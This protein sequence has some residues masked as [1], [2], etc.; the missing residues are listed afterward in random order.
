MTFFVYLIVSKNKGKKV[1]YVG[2]TKN[3]TNRILLHNNGKGA[4]FTKGRVW[5]LIYYKK[6]KTK[7]E[8]MVEEN[9]LKKNYKLRNLLKQ[10]KLI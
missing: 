9:K 8:A 1:S 7:S 6:Y 10:E 5:K 3:L 2:Y 4:K